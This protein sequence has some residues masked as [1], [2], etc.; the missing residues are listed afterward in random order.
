MSYVVQ[1]LTDSPNQVQP[2]LVPDGSTLTMTLYYRPQQKGWFLDL[3]WNG[4][5]PSWQNLGMRLITG[6]NIL[7]QYKNQLPFGLAVHTTDL[8][9][10]AGQEDLEDGYC[11]IILLNAEDVIG[12]EETYFPGN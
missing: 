1:G 3:S 10:P 11:T 6:P 12:V 5:T 8:A 4:Q 2:I 9:D 7:R